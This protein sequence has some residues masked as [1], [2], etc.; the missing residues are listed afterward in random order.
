MKQKIMRLTEG[1][2]YK[3]IERAARGIV[4]DFKNAPDGDSR[5]DEM[6]ANFSP[7]ERKGMEDWEKSYHD[8][9]DGPLDDKDAVSKNE[10]W[11]SQLKKAYPN[12]GDR[13]QAMNRA[14]KRRDAAFGRTNDKEKWRRY[15]KSMEE[16]G[17]G[18]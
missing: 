3:M 11:H 13:R 6:K 14:Y 1:E 17:C 5:I 12:S 16:E 7:Q 15:D 8:W 9:A 18:K 10:K 4:E 2:L